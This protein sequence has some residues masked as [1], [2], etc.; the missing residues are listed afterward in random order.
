VKS[1]TIPFET[2]PALL[3]DFRKFLVERISK[4]DMADHAFLEEGKWSD[5]LRSINDLIR[6][7]EISRL[8]FFLETPDR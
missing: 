5:S 3:Y 8:D 4:H 6:N 7:D 1:H 2:V